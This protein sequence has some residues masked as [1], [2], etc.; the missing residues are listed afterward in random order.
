MIHLLRC[1]EK[2]IT[3]ELTLSSLCSRL[4]LDGMKMQ[5]RICSLF[6]CFAQLCRCC[7]SSSFEGVESFTK[8]QRRTTT[9]FAVNGLS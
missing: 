8:L 3:D 1:F 6:I 9:F 7:G 4:G 2:Y 5:V